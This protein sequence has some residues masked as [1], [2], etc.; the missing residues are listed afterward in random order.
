MMDVIDYFKRLIS[1]FLVLRM[2]RSVMDK[3]ICTLIVL[4]SKSVIDL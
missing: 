4:Q 3:I 1:Y 2:D